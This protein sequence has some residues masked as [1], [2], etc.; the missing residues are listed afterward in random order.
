[1]FLYAPTNFIVYNVSC[2][3]AGMLRCLLIINTGDGV[4]NIDAVAIAVI[5]GV[6]VE[7][8]WPSPRQLGPRLGLGHA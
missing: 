6:A 1:M 2:T 4:S 7:P 8:A 5:V 3:Q